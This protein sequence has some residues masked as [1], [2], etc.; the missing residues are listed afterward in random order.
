MILSPFRLAL[1]QERGITLTL[2]GK[3]RKILNF[4]TRFLWMLW[5]CL[6]VMMNYISRQKLNSSWVTCWHMRI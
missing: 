2:L 1:H 5:V 3:L 6:F 4:L